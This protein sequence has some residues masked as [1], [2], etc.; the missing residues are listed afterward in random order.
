MSHQGLCREDTQFWHCLGA[1][2]PRLS[3]AAD[4][5]P[6]LALHTQREKGNH[7]C[8]P[9]HTLLIPTELGNLP[10]RRFFFFPRGQILARSDF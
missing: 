7:L 6:S 1:G 10:G 3:V 9:L 8:V 5:A 2:Q 4:V